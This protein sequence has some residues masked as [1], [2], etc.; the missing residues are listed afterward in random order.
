MTSRTNER[1]KA[2]NF[3]WTH[4][5]SLATALVAGALLAA[6]AAA[7]QHDHDEGGNYGPSGGEGGSSG[8]TTETSSLVCAGTLADCNQDAADGC[9]ADLSQSAE[10]CG[11]CGH[12]CQGSSC[13]ASQCLP[14]VL[15]SEAKGLFHVDASDVFFEGSGQ[16][17]RIDKHGEGASQLVAQLTFDPTRMAGSA[18][19]LFLSEGDSG[20]IWAVPKTGGSP[21]LFASGPSWDSTAP[22]LAVNGDRVYWS[23][24]GQVHSAPVSGGSSTMI[25]EVS[26]QYVLTR[27]AVDETNVFTESSSTPK[28]PA[29]FRAP[30]SGPSFTTLVQDIEPVGALALAESDVLWSSRVSY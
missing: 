24:G 28:G 25:G 26:S 17:A 30:K 11:Q 3:D 29:I 10:H 19:T 16:L 13:E 15:T 20:A 22:A 14:Q 4:V 6:C 1:T 21:S 8:A 7:S 12:S 9:E 27:I 18:T 5:A 23:F 2:A